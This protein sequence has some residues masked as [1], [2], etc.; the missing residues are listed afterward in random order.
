LPITPHL[1]YE[2]IKTVVLPRQHLIFADSFP[3]NALMVAATLIIHAAL[4]ALI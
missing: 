1:A 4:D 2:P 3:Q